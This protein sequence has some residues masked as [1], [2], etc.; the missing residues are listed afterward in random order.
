MLVVGALASVAAAGIVL[1]VGE[2]S[3]LLET[4]ELAKDFNAYLL[5]EPARAFGGLVAIYLTSYGA[6]WLVA[7]AVHRSDHGFQA[8]GSA[9]YHAFAKE[10]PPNAVPFLT[11]EMKDGRWI[12]GSYRKSTV[13]HDDN[14]E[15]CLGQPLGSAAGAGKEMQPE[16]DD[17]FILLREDEIRQIKGRYLQS[18]ETTDGKNSE[19]EARTEKS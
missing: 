17:A 15:L 16:L 13:E 4:D 3:G 2:R 10:C 18:F 11:V 7:R 19:V 6:A 8:D 12:A 9:W 1:V 14:R 5:T